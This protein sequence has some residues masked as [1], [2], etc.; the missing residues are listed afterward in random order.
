MM[1]VKKCKFYLP[2]EHQG[3]QRTCLKVAVHS[4]IKL[5]FGSVE[6]PE[7]NLSEQ[8]REPTT[9]STH[10]RCFRELKLGHI[11]GR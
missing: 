7:K 11:G 10:I 3:A 2:M 1:L 6:F 9:N 8:S 4:R 5:E